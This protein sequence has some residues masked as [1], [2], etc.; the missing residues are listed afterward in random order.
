[1]LDTAFV[2]PLGHRPRLAR[3]GPAAAPE[4]VVLLHGYPDNL[5]VFSALAPLLAEG[6]QVLAFDWPGLGDSAAW[7]GGTT[8]VALAQR[9]LALLDAWNLPRVHLVGQD[10][11]MQP[12]L[13]F[14]ATYPERLHSLTA[15]NGLA[16]GEVITS[17]EITWLRRLGLNRLLL[18]HLPRLVFGQALRTFLPRPEALPTPLRQELWRTFRQ[19]AVR[20]Y[21][22]RMCA[23]Y[24]AQLPR[25]PAR[26][27]QISCPV[28]ILWGANDK[29]FPV[30]QARYL[31]T[32]IPRARL[33]II[34]QAPHWM[35]LTHAPQ[36][37]AA[38]QRFWDGL[39]GSANLLL[40][41]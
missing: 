39:S 41:A 18:R 30:A 9:L 12:A 34:P 4:T 2:A 19:P 37:A 3:L 26:Y 6:R 25:L 35:V 17:W 24:E 36:V 1:M 32:L 11:G 22:V 16:G 7:P 23:G 20:D 5:Q 28:L 40:G 8:P 15:L 21:I 38:L 14:A 13:V 33:V 31:A 29:H 10:M 27:Q